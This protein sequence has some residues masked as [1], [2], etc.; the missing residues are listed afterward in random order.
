MADH[1]FKKISKIPAPRGF[2][3]DW[4][5][6]PGAFHRLNPPWVKARSKNKGG[7]C[8]GQEV[9]LQVKITGLW[10]RWV[11][12]HRGFVEGEQFI[13][14]QAAGPMASWV[15]THQFE[16]AGDD[17]SSMLMRDRIDYRMPMGLLGEMAHKLFARHDLERMFA[18]RHRLL[19]AD[20][21]DHLKHIEQPRMSVAL[22]GVNGLVGSSLRAFLTTGGH[23]V[24]PIVRRASGS[25]DEIVWDTQ[26]NTVDAD[27]MAGCDA[28]IH[29]AGSSIMG[30]WTRAKKKVVFDSR[31]AGTRAVCEAIA[32]M[33]R[34]PSVLICAS[35]IGYYGDRADEELTE[36][37]TAGEGFMT[38]V[39]QAWEAACR[40]AVD[41]GVRVVNLRIGVVLTPAGGALAQMLPVFKLG[42]GGRLGSGNHWWG[43][44]S[45]E[46]LIAAIHHCLWD[47]SIRGPVNAVAPVPVTNRDFTRVLAKALHRPAVLPVPRVAPRVLFGKEMADALL[48]GS[49]RV[50]PTRLQEA[51]FAFRQPTLDAALNQIL[52]TGK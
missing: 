39:C 33:D 22:S 6:R 9:E 12:R 20:I 5:L 38:E 8:E 29:L 42:L 31:V 50:L 21:A 35:A 16:S 37:S 32:G 41:A 1:V 3:W 4:H 14:E 11:A 2:V 18:Y 25:A 40:P 51:G 45:H 17:A 36:D 47:T 13:D 46:D 30:R 34:K 23:T 49:L 24:R 26:A 27:A 44:I 7:I 10:R 52:G 28:V 48:F 43:W 15:H 19:A